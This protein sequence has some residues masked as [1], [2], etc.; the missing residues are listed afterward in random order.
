MGYRAKLLQR[1]GTF[2]CCRASVALHDDAIGLQTQANAFILFRVLMLRS[3]LLALSQSPRVARFV[4]HNRLSRRVVR[5]FV[6]GERLDDAM[7]A[8]RAL[9]HAGRLASLD[10]LGESVSSESEA[11]SAARAYSDMFDRIAA[12]KLTCNVSLKLTQLGLDIRPSLC[13][14]LLVEIVKRAATQGNFVRIDMESSAY[15]QR[16]LDICKH[17]RTQ[18]D[19]VGTVIQSYLFRTEQ[20][21]QDL[22]A[23]GCRLRLVKGAYKEPAAVAFPKKADVDA[24]YVKV[25][26]ILLPSGIYHG[27]AT[28]DPN[29]LDATKKFAAEQGIRTDQFEFQMLY[30]IRTDLQ[31]QLIRE[32]YRLRVYVPYGSDWFPY[33]MRRLAERPANLKFFL[34]NLFRGD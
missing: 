25:M 6:A 23:A 16:T 17:A 28:H 31:E 29:M 3:T 34:S 15:T 10:C 8:V 7:A 4:I 11:R 21:A 1:I 27:I 9:N 19:S 12:E 20:D 2:R 30:G 14:E 18:S 13:E 32:G 24:N 5:R 33:F 22:I 26:K